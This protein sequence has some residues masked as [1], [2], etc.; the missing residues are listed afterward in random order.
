MIDHPNPRPVFES[1]IYGAAGIA[2]HLELTRLLLEYGADPNDEET[3]YHVPEGYDNA[4]MKLLLDSGT[5]NDESL[6]TMLLRK[7]DWHDANGLKLVLE[8][9]ANPN[10]MTRWGDN[11]LHHALRRDNHIHIIELLLDHGADP[12]LKNTRDG[13]SATVMGAHRGRGDVLALFEQQGLALDLHGVD[14]LIAACARDDR[15]TILALS[16]E[17]ALVAELIAQG[18]TLLAEFAGVGNVAG[19][20]NLLGLGVDVA[21]LYTEGD[22][23]FDIAKNSPPCTWP[24]GA[25]GPLPWKN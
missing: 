7:T 18:G 17:P 14:R 23:Y 4:V 15:E 2:R 9:G 21:S 13:R 20:R 10:A 12:A 16:G 3:P 22:P 11:A 24:P 19:L 6:T 1:A 5:L 25:R 8:Y